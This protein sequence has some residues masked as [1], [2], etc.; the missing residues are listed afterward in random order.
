MEDKKVVQKWNPSQEEIDHRSKW[1]NRCNSA[2]RQR[3]QEYDELD[4]MTYEDYFFTNLKNRNAYLAPKVNKEDVRV[5]SGITQ[6]KVHTMHSA[7]MNYNFSPQVLAFDEESYIDVEVGNVCEKL[8]EKSRKIEPIRH[9]EKKGL[10]V[11]EFLTQ[12]NVFVEEQWLEYRTKEKVL[13]KD[14]D[15]SDGVDPNKIKWDEKLG[16]VCK[17]CNTEMVTGLDLYVGNIRQFHMS[18]QPF[19]AIRRKVT[20]AEAEARFQNWE[21]WKY[22]PYEINKTISENTGNQSDTVSYNDWTMVETELDMVEI[23]ICQD[24]WENELQIFCNGI[25][26]LPVGF[27]LSFLLGVSEYTIAKGNCE[28]ISDRFFYCKGL[29]A[30]TKIDEALFNEFL[31][32]MIVKTRK[33]F[34]PTIIDNSGS[35]IGADIHLPGKIFRNV[36]HTKIHEFGKTDGVNAAEFNMVQ[37]IKAMIDNKTVSP[38]FEGQ[39]IDKAQTA[40]EVVELKEQ[41]LMKLGYSL[42]GWLQFEINLSWLRL[43]DIFT[44]WMEPEVEEIVGGVKAKKYKKYSMETDFDEEEKGDMMIELTDET[45][46]PSSEQMMA[47]EDIMKR[48][49]GRPVRMKKINV[50]WFKGFKDRFYIEMTP[51]EK[52]AGELKSVLFEESLMKAVGLFGMPSINQE[53]AKQ[54]WAVLKGEDP[55]KLFT[56]APAMP[57]PMPQQ[58]GEVGKQLMPEALNAPSLNT[59]V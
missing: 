28:P 27:P 35:K 44:H 3:Q 54:R 49:T 53:Y 46:L 23:V 36:N 55:E 7:L 58:G 56:K 59:L 25:P 15:W 26:M 1:I 11:L 5:V 57:Q 12:G 16:E 20:R 18:L 51:Q 24:K 19:I 37:F 40:R 33:S 52:S 30:K 38:V 22:V 41:T 9:E 39:S 47:R 45:E 4:G 50:A 2:L 31:K 13:S 32:M 8:I 48:K 43:H 29:S 34:K 6:E 10:Y 21:R 14:L 42:M 17:V